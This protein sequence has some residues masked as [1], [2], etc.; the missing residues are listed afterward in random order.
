MS[1]GTSSSYKPSKEQEDLVQ[2]LVDLTLK[3]REFNANG[4]L[5][6]S[7]S[8]F[9]NGKEINIEEIVDELDL[10]SDSEKDKSKDAETKKKS[11]VVEESLNEDEHSLPWFFIT[12]TS[13]LTIFFALIHIYFSPFTKIEEA[14]NIDAIHDI[15][16][17]GISDISSYEHLKHSTQFPTSFIGP[18]IIAGFLKPLIKLG[19]VE[20]SYK[21]TGLAVQI[22]ARCVIAIIN[23]LSIVFFKNCVQQKILNSLLTDL[24]VHKKNSPIEIDSESLVAPS[25]SLSYWVDIFLM[26][27]FHIMYYC[28]RSLPN[29]VIAFA[30]VNIAMGLMVL[31]KTD[32]SVLI[33]A[34]SGLV[35]RIELAV[36]CI[37]LVSSKIITEVFFTK[38]T[39]LKEVLTLKQGYGKLLKFFVLGAMIGGSTSYIVDSYFWDYKTIPEIE[40]FIN[41]G[42]SLKTAAWAGEP[43]HAYFTKYLLMFFLP[44]TVLVLNYYG[45]QY[46]YNNIKTFLQME[47]AALVYI[48]FMSFQS[49]KEWKTICYILPI[50]II[51]GS[52]GCSFSLIN[53]NYKD[54]FGI[55]IPIL[56][57]CSPLFSILVSALFSFISS[58]NYPGGVALQQFNNYILEN[59]Y[60]DQRVVVHMDTLACISGA[61][62]FGEINLPDYHITYDKTD[63]PEQI[64]SDWETYDFLIGQYYEDLNDLQAMNY[65]LIFK[66][67]VYAGVNF[68]HVLVLKDKYKFENL[69]GIVKH[70]I[71]ARSASLIKELWDGIINFEDVVYVWKKE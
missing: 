71:E 58:L 33:L 50:F 15:L 38:E 56:I 10:L 59:N 14:F 24:S 26:G 52:N 13:Y 21:G 36:I 18:L 46:S 2:E 40:S 11:L 60:K 20:N 41:K 37:A 35:F 49:H 48:G 47:L 55:L 6:Y 12:P 53:I 45:L 23:I 70:M 39:T 30:L 57:S 3:G 63:D 66:A 62:L 64:A 19:L 16:K 7:D 69:Y 34:F 32:I 65:S 51:I 5:V 31:N 54:S 67:P 42:L 9:K 43:I 68:K 25:S 27:Q 29:F 1:Q 28:S 61:S 4:E 8:K 22:A 44:P 17:Y